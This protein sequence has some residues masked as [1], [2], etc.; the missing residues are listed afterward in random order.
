MCLPG[1]KRHMLEGATLFFFIDS[2]AM[3]T[4]KVVYH[5]PNTLAQVSLNES[6]LIG[7]QPI[8]SQEVG[9]IVAEAPRLAPA[10]CFW[11]LVNP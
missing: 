8:R 2:S 11:L 1:T 6:V 10:R 7:M 9:G 3:Y 4:R 5:P